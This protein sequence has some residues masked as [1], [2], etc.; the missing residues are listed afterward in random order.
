MMM[1]KALSLTI[2]MAMTIE[3]TGKMYKNESDAEADVKKILQKNIK[4]SEKKGASY[5]LLFPL[6]E[7]LKS[8]NYRIKERVVMPIPWPN[9]DGDY[10]NGKGCIGLVQECSIKGIPGN[11]RYVIKRQNG[12]SDDD[13]ETEKEMNVSFGLA[14]D[15]QLDDRYLVMPYVGLNVEAIMDSCLEGQKTQPLRGFHPGRLLDVFV[16]VFP[17]MEIIHDKYGYCYGDFHLGNITYND[18]KYLLIDLA[19]KLGSECECNRRGRE[20][21][22]CAKFKALILMCLKQLIFRDYS[23]RPDEKSSILGYMYGEE[24]SSTKDD[25]NDVFEQ[26]EK[27]YFGST[28]GFRFEAMMRDIRDASPNRKRRAVGRRLAQSGLSGF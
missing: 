11:R 13:W 2:L 24:W 3:V 6:P 16:D 28:E 21:S 25:I 18:N 4:D 9:E 8:L 23:T 14:V 1:Y 26:L 15:T 20:V 12:E 22:K 17:T 10:D 5:Y 7:A 19:P 27:D